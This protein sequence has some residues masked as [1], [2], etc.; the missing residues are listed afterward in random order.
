MPSPNPLARAKLPQLPLAVIKQL[1]GTSASGCTYSAAE[2]AAL[3]IDHSVSPVEM[4]GGETAAKARWDEIP[5]CEARSLLR[6]PQS[7]GSRGEPAACR[8]IFILVTSPPTRSSTAWPNR[9]TGTP[10]RLAEKATGRREGWWGMGE[11]AEAFI[12]QLVTWREVGLNCC[13][14]QAAYDRYESLPDWAKATLAKHAGDPRPYVYTLDDLA[15]G[16]THDRLWNAAQGQLVR[17]GQMHNYLR[18]LWGKKILQWT[19]S[20]EESLRIMI[21]L[22]NRYALDGQDPNSYSGI[23]WTLGRYDRPLGT[24]A[25]HLWHGSLHDLGEHGPERSGLAGTS[26]AMQARTTEANSLRCRVEP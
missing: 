17:E 22:N 6:R 21:E 5:A 9:K 20:P 4:M 7:A 26:N 1:G 16:R 18:M 11:A 13:A 15:A 25:T 23:F 8:P 19:A 12:D 24:G 14:T 2:L 3:P 10:D